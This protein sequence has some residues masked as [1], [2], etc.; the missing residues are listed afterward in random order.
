MQILNF[1]ILSAVPILA[2]PLLNYLLMKKMDSNG[3]SSE[4]DSLIKMLLFSPGLLGQNEHQGSQ[5]NS[6]L[7]FLFYQEEE[8][9]GEEMSNT[10]LLMLSLM[11]STTTNNNLNSMLPMLMMSEGETDLKSLF[12]MLSTMQANCDSTNGQIN[13]LLPYF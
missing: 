12:L 11:Q 8:N 7:P 4:N 9:G 13:S 10:K 5:M 6:L 2:N 3:D 1:F